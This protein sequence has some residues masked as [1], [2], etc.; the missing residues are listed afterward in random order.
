MRVGLLFVWVSALAGMFFVYVMF[1]VLMW[2]MGPVDSA[3]EDVIATG[4][5]D[6]AWAEFYYKWRGQYQ[7]FFGYFLAAAFISLLIYLLVNS[8]RREEDVYPVAG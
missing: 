5:V 6:S 2:V 4:A 1:T 3:A 7:E 8:A